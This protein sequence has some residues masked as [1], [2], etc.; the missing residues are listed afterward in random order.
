[1]SE[2]VSAGGP[3]A[4]SDLPANDPPAND[5]PANDSA[6]ADDLV[7]V[8]RIGPTRGLNGDVLVEPWTDAPEERFREGA[9]LQTGSGA[10]LTVQAA[11]LSAGKQVVHFAGVDG[12]PDAEALRGT[13][14]Y[15]RAAERPALHDP[16][17]YYDT[18]LVGLAVLDTAG[19]RIGTVRSVSHAASAAYLVVEVEGRECL[20]PF[21]AAIV[22]SVDVAAGRVV[23]DP[24]EGLFEL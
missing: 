17:E 10:P 24:P 14:L 4:A 1:V 18:D 12:R 21:V 8:G 15:V 13:E 16:D 2:P 23:V 20:V 9:A 7:A 19:N 3:S 11:Y 6:A 5:P 22:P